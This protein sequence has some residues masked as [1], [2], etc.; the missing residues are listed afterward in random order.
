MG[1]I[2]R[3]Q[4]N[5]YES[6]R[7]DM[8]RSCAVP[9]LCYKIPNGKFNMTKNKLRTVSYI[10]WARLTFAVIINQSVLI[11]ERIIENQYSCMTC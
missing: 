6:L 7:E 4:E 11:F 9:Y 8:V 2:M 10:H 1:M 3:L 5:D